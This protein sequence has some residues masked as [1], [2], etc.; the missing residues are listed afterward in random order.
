LAAGLIA[1]GA[2]MAVVFAEVST[3]HLKGVKRAEKSWNYFYITLGFALTIAGTII[4]M[5]DIIKVISPE[6]TSWLKLSGGGIGFRK[7]SSTS[8]C[9]H[10]IE[11]AVE[12]AAETRDAHW[13]NRHV[14][15]MFL[16]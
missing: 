2:A 13:R 5:V 1:L 10:S 6:W 9:F 15:S 16:H 8:I 12:K 4:Q 14:R 7:L 3:T 11:K